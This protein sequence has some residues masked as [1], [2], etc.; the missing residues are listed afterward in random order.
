MWRRT[1][2][3]PGLTGWQWHG[4]LIVW[5]SL[6]LVLGIADPGDMSV[7]PEQAVRSPATTTVHNVLLEKGMARSPDGRSS[8]EIA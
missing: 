8:P 6:W 3:A 5:R 4:K 7:V 1:L 2:R